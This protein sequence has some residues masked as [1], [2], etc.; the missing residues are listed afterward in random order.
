MGGMEVFKAVLLLI[1]FGAI[2]F[3][4][5]VTAKYVGGRQNKAMRGRNISIVETVSLG[6]DKRLHLVKAGNQYVLI[7][8]TS[9]TVEFMTAVTLDEAGAGQPEEA[10][11]AQESLNPFDFKTLFE[12]YVNTYKT[13]KE[14]NLSTGNSAFSRE[15]PENRNFKSNLDRL[16]T[17]TQ[18]SRYQA[19][20]NGDDFTNEK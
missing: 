11:E 14:K 1:G 19:K 5:Y 12:K 18:K 2:L 10:R 17:V 16:R 20:E 7:A 8:S 9:K 4:A 15:V 3:L 6:M 13:K